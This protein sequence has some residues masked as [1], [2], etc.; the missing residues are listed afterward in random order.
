MESQSDRTEFAKGPLSAG[1]GPSLVT[2]NF[3]EL[4]QELQIGV[5]RGTVRISRPVHRH[6]EEARS[7]SAHAQDLNLGFSRDPRIAQPAGIMVVAYGRAREAICLG[8]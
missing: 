5:D 7:H 2:I 4:R 8:T 1:P 6:I 3:D